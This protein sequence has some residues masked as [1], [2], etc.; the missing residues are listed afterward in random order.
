MELDKSRV[1]TAVNAD[2][3]K[4]GSR[5]IF[6]NTILSLR[7]EVESLKGGEFIGELIAILDDNLVNRLRG[8][9]GAYPLAYLIEPPAEPKYKP[10]KDID[11]AMEAIK[12]H[13]GWVS[14]RD[15]KNY[16]FIT[17]YVPN[18][19]EESGIC[20]GPVWHTLQELYDDFIFTDDGS[21]CGELV[22]E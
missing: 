11:K 18:L 3:L 14:R 19:N 6:A 16:F 20:I 10:F 8:E 21:P 7:E 2:E 5:C 15:C 1:Y 4:I 17:G 12:K 22:E 13:G 9:K